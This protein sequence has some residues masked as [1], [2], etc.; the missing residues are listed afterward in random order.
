M[1]LQEI[2]KKILADAQKEVEKINQTAEAPIA[3][4][5]KESEAKLQEA[6]AHLEK[7]TEEKEKNMEQRLFSMARRE[8]AKRQLAA[9]QKVIAQVLE[10]FHDHLIKGED[11]LYTEVVSPLLEKVFAEFEGREITLFVP[12]N[13]K[14]LT[15]KLSDGKKVSVQ[16][17]GEVA[18]GFIAEIDHRIIVDYSFHNLIYSEYNQALTDFLIKQFKYLAS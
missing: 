12:Q 3:A 15:E 4:L 10:K 1:A 17:S 7:K 9:K 6:Q 14:A 5:Q 13:R 18:G 16:E 11:S 2:L 8:N